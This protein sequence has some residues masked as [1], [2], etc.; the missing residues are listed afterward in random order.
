MAGVLVLYYRFFET[1]PIMLRMG[2]ISGRPYVRVMTYKTLVSSALKYLGDC[3]WEYTTLLLTKQY[4][5]GVLS[6]TTPLFK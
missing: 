4:F 6:E 2:K 5:N 1:M 3:S